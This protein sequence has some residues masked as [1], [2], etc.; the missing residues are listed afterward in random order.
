MLAGISDISS[1]TTQYAFLKLLV[2]TFL[3][4]FSLGN[5]SSPSAVL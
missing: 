4:P 2:I 3:W 1:L 5:C